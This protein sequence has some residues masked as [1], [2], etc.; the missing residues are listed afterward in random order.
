MTAT[1]VRPG[2]AGGA[3]GGRDRPLNAVAAQGARI[4]V[5]A[6][7][8]RSGARWPRWPT[9]PILPNS[10][11]SRLRLRPSVGVSSLVGLDVG[12]QLEPGAVD[13]ARHC[14][15]RRSGRASTVCAVG[16]G[17]LEGELARVCARHNTSRAG[18]ELADEARPA[19][20]A[21]HRIAIVDAGLD[22]G[23]QRV[24]EDIALMVAD[25]RAAAES[26]PRRA[27]RASRARDPMAEGHVVA[28]S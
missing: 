16:R 28:I 26:A 15:P 1:R 7:C 27:R 25:A 14:R 20:R 6:D 2:D 18:I 5:T 4:S 12:D 21:G 11:S 10:S 22:R 3:R 24:V 8:R 17:M 23:D 13:R 19:E 9:A